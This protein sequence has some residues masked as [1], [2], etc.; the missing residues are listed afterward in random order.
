[1][2]RIVKR[3]LSDSQ[4]EKKHAIFSIISWDCF[5]TDPDH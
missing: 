4:K 5:L 2:S 1:M 3:V